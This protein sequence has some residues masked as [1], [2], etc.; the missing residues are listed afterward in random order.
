MTVLFKPQVE[1]FAN[2]KQANRLAPISGAVVG[3]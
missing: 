1:I 3:Q 2:S